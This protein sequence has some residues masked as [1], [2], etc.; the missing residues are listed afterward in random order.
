VKNIFTR[1]GVLTAVSLRIQVFWDVML[2]HGVF[3]GIV[4]EHIAFNNTGSHQLTSHHITKGLNPQE[5]ICDSEI[6]LALVFI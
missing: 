4:K 6:P 3:P 5:C 2:C 1:F